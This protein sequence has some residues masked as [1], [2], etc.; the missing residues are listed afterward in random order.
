[1]VRHTLTASGTRSPNCPPAASLFSP[2]RLTTSARTRRTGCGSSKALE[3]RSE[4]DYGPAA[5]RDIAAKRVDY[6]AAGTLV[7]WD[8]DP[9]AETIL[10]YKATDPTR[11]IVFRKRD[12]A[13]AEPAVPGWRM[14][15]SDVFTP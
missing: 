15:V 12:T 6:F 13:D 5:D 4:N 2:T 3:V 7:V 9:L 8:V 14:P 10:C 11:P 1:V